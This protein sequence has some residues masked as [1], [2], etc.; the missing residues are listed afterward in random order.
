MR[1]LFFI[2]LQVVVF[3]GTDALCQEDIA[4]GTVV[5]KVYNYA[6]APA[7]ILAKAEDVASHIFVKVG[8]QLR[9]VQ[10]PLVESELPRF[11]DCSRPQTQPDLILKVVGEFPAAF[12]QPAD[13]MGFSLM[14]TDQPPLNGFV[15]YTRVHQRHTEAHISEELLLGHVLSHE[16]ATSCWVQ[17]R[18][19]Q[20]ES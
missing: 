1:R 13:S 15:A 20:P 16:I 17:T 18:T 19:R 7:S 10:C 5:I 9:W 11:P 3:L 4:S 6:Q 12:D 2:T 8:L 14:T